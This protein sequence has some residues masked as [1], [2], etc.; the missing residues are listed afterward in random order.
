MIVML[1]IIVGIERSVCV[2]DCQL[3]IVY[4]VIQKIRVVG[5]CELKVASVLLPVTLPNA[6]RF[7]GCIACMHWIDAVYYCRCRT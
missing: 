2:A 6:G 1:L 3:F 4:M 5:R 7:L